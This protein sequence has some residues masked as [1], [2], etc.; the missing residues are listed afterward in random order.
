MNLRLFAI[1]DLTTGRIVP[2][3]FFPSKQAAKSKRD[4]LGITSHCVTY[5][6]DHRLYKR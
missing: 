4:E 3:L 6:P 1:R 5:G 2:D